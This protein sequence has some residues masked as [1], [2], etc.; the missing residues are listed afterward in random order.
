M[1]CKHCNDDIHLSGREFSNH[2]R[3]CTKNPKR[4]EYSDALHHAR[5]SKKTYSNQHIKA[6]LEGKKIE[7]SNETREKISNAHKGKY[8]TEEVKQMLSEKRKMWLKQN[9]DLHPWKR[10]DKFKSVPCE[11][12]KEI[13]RLE[14]FEFEEEFSPMID[15]H[16]SLDI[17]FPQ[18]KCGIEV[19]GEQHYTR[20][21]V[22]KRYYQERHDLIVSTGWKLLELHY[23]ECYDQNVIE[24]I[25]FFLS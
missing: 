4:K 25:R 12:L 17:A 2:V 5:S 22:L 1:I 7:V 6:K 13:L 23:T 21:K 9:P 11:K 19:N 20:R 18:S 24:R 8:H 3:W 15:R 14:G 16:F 10:S